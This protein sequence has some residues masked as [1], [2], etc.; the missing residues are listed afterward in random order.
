MRE[1]GRLDTAINEYEKSIRDAV[2][3]MLECGYTRIAF[4]S[5]QIRDVMPRIQRRDSYLAAM[6][7]L[8]PS[9]A[10]PYVYEFDRR[11]PA[12]C[13][14]SLE[15]YRS[16][17]PGERLAILSVN[18]A[19]GQQLLMTMK[20]LNLQPGRDLGLCTFDDWAVFSL[21]DVTTIRLQTEKVGAA[22]AQ[23]LLER[24]GESLPDAAP[25]RSMELPTELIVRSSV[26]RVGQRG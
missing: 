19:T 10:G 21:A 12:S 18:G 5:E 24:I 14:S 20:S 16:A 7:A 8:A 4:F 13:L 25:A 17:F 6:S 9:E 11:D 3:L 22:A 15:D 23:M 1:S 26:V 2:R